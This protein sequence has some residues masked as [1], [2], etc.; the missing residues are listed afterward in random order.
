MLQQLVFLRDLTEQLIQGLHRLE[1]YL[2][3]EGFLEKFLK[4][5]S[6]L[7]SAGETLQDLEKYLN[8]IFS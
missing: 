5:K 3:K 2:N 4:M 8:F 6:T 1:K 7:N